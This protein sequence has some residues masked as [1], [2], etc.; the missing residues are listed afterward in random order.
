MISWTKSMLPRPS[1]RGFEGGAPAPA[2]GG[3]ELIPKGI[4]LV[5][6]IIFEKLRSRKFETYP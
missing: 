6:L 3:F 5:A 1:G 4:E 2:A